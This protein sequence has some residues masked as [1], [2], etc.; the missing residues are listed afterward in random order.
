MMRCLTL[1]KLIASTAALT[2]SSAL[3]AND[4]I[5]GKKPDAPIL[6]TDATLYTVSSGVKQDHDLLIKDGK[7][8]AIGQDLTAPTNAT[9]INGEGKHVYPGLIGLTTT[10]GLVEI[11][12]VRA[13]RD[14]AETGRATPEVKAHI[15]FNAD[16]E[17]I[18]TIR[19]NG[20]THVEVAPTGSGLNGQSS[21]MHLDGWNWQDALVKKGT[22]MHLRWPRA[23]INKSFWETRTPKKQ[24]ED[25]AKALKQL[26]DTFEQIKA[27]H[28]ARSANAN[29]AID[30]RWEAMRPVLDKTMPL[31]V[32]AN[33]YR[34]I[35]SAIH[36]AKQQDIKIVLVGVGDADKAIELIKSNNIPVVFTSAWGHPMRSD[37]GLDRAYKTPAVLEQNGISY[38]LAIN[39]NWNVRDLPFAA[40]Q[41]VAYGVSPS[42]ALKSVTLEPA[43]ILGVAD[44]MGSLEVGKQANIVIS[45]GDLFD[46]LTHKVDTV[47]IEGRS[48]DLNNRHKQLYDKYSKKN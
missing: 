37:E 43:K 36:F 8:A 20:I 4:M 22:G 17:I 35:E 1:T 27:Y 5:P 45:Q 15:A 24:K 46:H 25:N 6:I 47:M 10:V 19:S 33:D 2:L 38:A 30:V 7:I 11:G 12:A 44:K 13:T 31:F 14:M 34:Q 9:V 18:P 48:I 16:S 26:S 41:T 3:L 39:G 29:A 32:H 42:T 28:K 21:L 23:G 40:G